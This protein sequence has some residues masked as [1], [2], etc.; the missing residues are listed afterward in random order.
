MAHS[1]EAVLKIAL[2]TWK[3]SW[4]Q[5]CPNYLRQLGH[6]QVSHA[7]ANSLGVGTL[8]NALTGQSEERPRHEAQADL[9]RLN[10]LA[11]DTMVSKSREVML[12]ASIMASETHRIQ[13]VAPVC[14]SLISPGAQPLCLAKGPRIPNPGQ[15]RPLSFSDIHRMSSIKLQAQTLSPA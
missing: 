7:L 11:A 2:Y 15:H 5:A 4:I 9:H 8:L 14:Q 3:E 10:I 13:P 6:A 12:S 1:K